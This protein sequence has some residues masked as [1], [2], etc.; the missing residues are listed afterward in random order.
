MRSF[1]FSIAIKYLILL[2][3]AYFS[4]LLVKQATDF[5]NSGKDFIGLGIA[6]AGCFIA[7]ALIE[8]N[9]VREANKD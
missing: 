9:D 1:R 4:F 2:G 7:F 8:N 3:G 6:A 5:Y